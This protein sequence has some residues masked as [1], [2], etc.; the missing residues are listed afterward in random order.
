MKP[1]L[2]DLWVKNRSVFGAAKLAKKANQI[3]GITIG[4]DKC[5]RL[6]RQLGIRGVSRK[7]SKT[8]NTV[9]DDSQRPVDLVDRLFTADK[10]NDLWVTDLT[11]VPTKAGTAYVCFILDVYSRSIVGWTVASHMKTEM[12]LDALEMAANDRNT[13]LAGLRLHSD[14]GSQ[15]TSLRWTERLEEIGASPSIGSIADSY[16]NAMA[17]S[18]NA[19]YKTELI[20]HPENNGWDTVADVELA[21]L[22]YVHWWNNDRPHHSLKLLTPNQKETIY[23]KQQLKNLAKTGS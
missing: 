20:Y 17:E 15:Y 2:Y 19:L 9:S 6:M 4:R 5:A 21:T 14:A 8:I 22:S 10:P 13:S 7:R 23:N 1:I 11:Y 3:D 18:V 12:V 16:D